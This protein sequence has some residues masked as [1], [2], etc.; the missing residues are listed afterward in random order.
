MPTRGGTCIRPCFNQPPWETS[1]FSSSTFW[2]IVFSPKGR[3]TPSCCEG[4]LYMCFTC[5]RAAVAQ[6]VPAL[7]TWATKQDGASPAACSLRPSLLHVI[8]RQEWRSGDVTCTA[9]LCCPCPWWALEAL[10]LPTC[11]T[12]SHRS[13]RSP[14]VPSSP[15]K[16]L[17]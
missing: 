10:V 12:L 5:S 9:L 8:V 6:A 17:Q 13:W 11:P 4:T 16:K 15:L 2:V 7:Q 14:V 3:S 1:C